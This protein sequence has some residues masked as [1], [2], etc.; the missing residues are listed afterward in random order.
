M[1]RHF[2]LSSF[3]T[4]V[5]DWTVERD[6]GGHKVRVKATKTAATNLQELLIMSCD[7]IADRL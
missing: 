2:L 4:S 1:K 6:A 3:V 5:V 7:I